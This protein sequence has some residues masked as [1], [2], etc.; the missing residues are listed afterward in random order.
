LLPRNAV[1]LLTPLRR[2]VLANWLQ[3]CVDEYSGY[4]QTRFERDSS[5]V[6][7]LV[8]CSRIGGEEL[9]LSAQCFVE[10]APV[11]ADLCRHAGA[12]PWSSYCANSFGGKS[13]FLTRLPSVAR[14]FAHSNSPHADYRDLIAKG[15]A[16]EFVAYI[17]NRLSRGL[18]LAK[19]SAP[20]QRVLVT[21]RPVATAPDQVA[22]PQPD[23]AD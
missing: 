6:N 5:P 23:T 8:G 20:V 10:S 17:E 4:F 13:R 15:L 19:S 1:L 3:H 9:N 12:H 18:P 2:G 7:N 22:I 14:R 16:P 21:R 11:R